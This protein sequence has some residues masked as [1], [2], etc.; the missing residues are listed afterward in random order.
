MSRNNIRCTVAGTTWG[1]N[2]S[3]LRST[4]LAMTYSVA[5]YCAPVWYRSSHTHK[6]DV[7]LNELMRLI[8]GTVKPTPIVL[9]PILTNIAPPQLRR[10]AAADKEWKKLSNRLNNLPIQRGLNP[11]PPDRLKSP[12]PSGWIEK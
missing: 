10:T 1:A 3:T 7:Q 6:I 4:A 5:E 2:A 9:L 12:A 11:P 8:T